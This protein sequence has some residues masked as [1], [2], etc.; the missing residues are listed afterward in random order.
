MPRVLMGRRVWIWKRHTHGSITVV[1]C[2]AGVD[3]S[4]PPLLI[5]TF[6]ETGTRW[7]YHACPAHRWGVDM[8]LRADVGR[9]G[10]KRARPERD[11]RQQQ[12][13]I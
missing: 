11:D 4:E 9:W 5:V 3:F 12:L 7:N 10:V 2:C 13:G 6:P 8:Q 1:H